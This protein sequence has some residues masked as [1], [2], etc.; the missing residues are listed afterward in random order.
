MAVAVQTDRCKA[1]RLVTGLCADPGRTF[2]QCQGRRHCAEIRCA[3]LWTT[4]DGEPR[5]PV[6]IRRGPATV[7]RVAGPARPLSPSGAG[8]P[9]PRGCDPRAR[10]LT[11]VVLTTRGGFPRE[12]I[13][14]RMR[15]TCAR[16]WRPRPSSAFLPPAVLRGIRAVLIAGPRIR[17]VSLLPALAAVQS[18]LRKDGPRAPDPIPR[19]QVSAGAAGDHA[20]RRLR[21]TRRR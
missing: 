16:A 6:R 13:E 19:G 10:R 21:R 8:R 9:G 7:S 3:N 17:S 5:K 2:T 20:T 12:R 4:N 18:R 14:T 1:T 15:Y 11:A